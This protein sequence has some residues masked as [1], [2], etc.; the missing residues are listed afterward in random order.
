MSAPITDY[1]AFQAARGY[2]ILYRRAE[3]N[4][5][6]A[7]GHAAWLVGRTMAECARCA[8]AI[9]LMSPVTPAQQEN[10]HGFTS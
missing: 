9:P 6:P 1:R 5:C 4:H 8:T 10:D 2:L 7:C 3:T